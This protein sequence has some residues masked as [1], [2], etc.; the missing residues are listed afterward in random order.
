MD[1]IMRW[2]WLGG[3]DAGSFKVEFIWDGAPEAG[4]NS[5]E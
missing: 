1:I 4:T 3:N 2:Q 5:C